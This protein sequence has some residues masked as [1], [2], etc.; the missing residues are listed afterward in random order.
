[1]GMSGSAPGA[2]E[3]GGG[4]LAYTV[5]GRGALSAGQLRELE[6]RTGRAGLADALEGWAA[7]TLFDAPLG[8]VGDVVFPWYYFSGGMKLTV[9]GVPYRFSFLQPQNTMGSPGAAGIPMGRAVGKSW[10][11][12]L[13]SAM[14]GS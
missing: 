4:R 7:V 10:R 9:A 1:M 5:H 8:A 13:T 3:I 2:L 11:E 6:R 14:S 12:I